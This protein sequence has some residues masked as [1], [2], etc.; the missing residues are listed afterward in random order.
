MSKYFL[1]I[2]IIGL[3]YQLIAQPKL[4]FAD[5]KKNFGFVKNGEKVK[6]SFQ[7]ANTGNQPLIITETK[8]GCS[9]TEVSWPKEPI[10]PNQSGNIEVVFDT[11]PAHGRQDR[12]IEIFSNDAN[13]PQKVRFKGVVLK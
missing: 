11:S 2:L 7:F 9:C 5:T 8:A 13:S 12:I 4:K 10:L 6:F 1:S 3:S